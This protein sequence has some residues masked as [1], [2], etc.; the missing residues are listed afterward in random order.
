[1]KLSQLAGLWSKDQGF[2][3]F[4]NEGSAFRSEGSSFG[5]NSGDRDPADLIREKCAISSRRDLDSNK[6]AAEVFNREFRHPYIAWAEQNSRSHQ[7]I[8]TML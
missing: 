1:M 7:A 6:A 2:I 5:L 3:R 4:L 8:R